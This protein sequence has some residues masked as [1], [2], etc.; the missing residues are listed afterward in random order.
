MQYNLESE[1]G[2]ASI[3]ILRTARRDSIE[4]IS[5]NIA[6]GHDVSIRRLIGFEKLTVSS[7]KSLYFHSC[8]AL[9]INDVR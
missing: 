5:M 3:K 9:S 1:I 6:N 4:I 2:I 8:G 7:M